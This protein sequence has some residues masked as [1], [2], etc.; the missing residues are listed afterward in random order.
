MTELQAAL[1]EFLVSKKFDL[2]KNTFQ[3][4]EFRI[5]KFVKHC[6]KAD[7]RAPADLTREMFFS[8]RETWHRYSDLTQKQHA[9]AIKAFLKVHMYRHERV[10]RVM[11]DA[12]EIIFELFARYEHDPDDLP[13]E[14][15]EGTREVA[16]G[17]RA[18]R[19]GNFIAGMTDRFALTEHHRLFDSTPDLR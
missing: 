7:A 8:Y 2:R 6:T 19:I 5:S 1:A 16:G 11:K 3:Q 12:E 17:A 10:M 13:L 9:S 4:L 14:W 18:R 15:R